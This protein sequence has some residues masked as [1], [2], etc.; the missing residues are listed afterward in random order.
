MPRRPATLKVVSGAQRTPG[1]VKGQGQVVRF[2]V[3]YLLLATYLNPLLNPSSGGGTGLGRETSSSH[4][5]VA[6][7][8]ERPTRGQGPHRAGQSEALGHRCGNQCS[9]PPG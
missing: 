4:K 2:R 1:K 9:P 6:Q 8:A 5:P 3:A 7:A